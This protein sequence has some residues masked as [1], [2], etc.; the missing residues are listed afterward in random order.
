MEKTQNNEHKIHKNIECEI[1][2]NSEYEIFIDDMTITGEGV[3][4]INGYAL[5]VKDA[6]PGDRI[7]AKVIKI[8][9]NYGYGRLMK[10]LVPSPSRV[11]PPCMVSRA[12][13]GC[14]LMAMDYKAQLE[15]KKSII[16][17]NLKRLG[18][19]DLE[20][21]PD[22][23]SVSDDSNTSNAGD[24]T[25]IKM[26]DV[27]GMDEPY[28]Y[29]NKAQFP[30][31]RDKNGCIVSGFY[32]GRTH[33]I[34]PCE[35][36]LIGLEAN[37]FILDAIKS[38]MERFDIEPYD[39]ASHSGLVRHI[40]IRAGFATGELMVCPVINGNSIPGE[41]E[42]IKSLL[43]LDLRDYR[44]TSIILNYNTEKTNVILGGKCRTI[45]GN[46]YIEDYI[47]DVKFRISP[48]SFYQ[49]NPVQ[50]K[51]LYDIALDYADLHGGETVF[52]LYCGIGTISLFLAQKAGHV[53]GVEIVP[54]AIEDA[55]QNAALNNINNAS[56][57]VGAAEEIAP[58]LYEK[59]GITADVVVVDPPR[60]GC[61]ERLI[62]TILTMAPSRIV[63]VSCDSATLARDLKLLLTGGYELQKIQGVDQF[64][65]SGHVETVVCLSK[66]STMSGGHRLWTDRSGAETVKSKKIRV[67]FSLEDMDTDGFKKGATYNAIRDWIKEKYGY[68]VTNLNIAQVK[69]K[70]GIIERENYNKPKSPDSK[71]PGCPGEKVKAIEDAMRHFK[72]I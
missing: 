4:R 54:Q 14:S 18:G 62:S 33:D 63:Y 72:M 2:K 46:D 50:T 20:K 70:H 12:C 26:P 39:E 17:N 11:D 45:Y 36:C 37:R 19:I 49:V 30:I 15:Y 29:R 66:G 48:L 16:I 71:Q 28:R 25:H 65:H 31:G 51:K 56:F 24:F 27:I 69:Q 9:K 67:E 64:C 1:L 47:G 58:M 40:L 44:I 13:G 7:I 68:R 38:H 43:A 42:L 23:S 5:F 55:K 22:A 59:N 21:E 34:I 10:I 6:L 53:Y 3:G 57:Y 60:K 41:D 32:A 35:D 61:D 8:K 52:D